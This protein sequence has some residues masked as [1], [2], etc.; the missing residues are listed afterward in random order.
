MIYEYALEPRLVVDWAIARIGRYVR[1]FGLDQR[2]LVSDFPKDWQNCVVGAFYE[3]FDYDDTSLEFQNTQRDL[4]AYLQI[5]TDYMV[6]RNIKVPLDCNWLDAALSEHKSRPF[7][8]IFVSKNVTTN[9]SR[10]CGVD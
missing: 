3:Y 5:L 2:R 7:Y 6:H 4:D 8:A 1:Q 10:R 9:V